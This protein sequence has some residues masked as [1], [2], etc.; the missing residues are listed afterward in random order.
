MNTCAS[1]ILHRCRRTK[2]ARCDTDGGIQRTALAPRTGFAG[3]GQASGL[4]PTARAS[5][6]RD[7]AGISPASLA[8]APP[9]LLPR[10][11]LRYRCEAAASRGHATAVLGGRRS[12]VKCQVAVRAR[13]ADQ[14]A[15][16]GWVIHWVGVIADRS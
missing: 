13:T 6:L 1:A 4:I 2:C 11:W 8:P 16:F 3:T 7:S 12:E 5:P 10:H 15:A 9:R 14:G